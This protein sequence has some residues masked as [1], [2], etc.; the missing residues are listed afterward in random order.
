MTV[1]CVHFIAPSLFFSFAK[2]YA[3][4]CR[5]KKLQ[6]MIIIKWDVFY[7]T[8]CTNTVYYYYYYY[9]DFCSIGNFQEFL[10]VKLRAPNEHT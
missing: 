1:Y 8:Q 10:P 2:F 6:Q 9:Y 5:H 4:W 3:Y 7:E